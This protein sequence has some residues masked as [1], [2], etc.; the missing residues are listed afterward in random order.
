MWKTPPNSLWGLSSPHTPNKTMWEIPSLSGRSRS[1]FQAQGRGDFRILHVFEVP[2]LSQDLGTLLQ[3]KGVWTHAG[4]LPEP[5]LFST[6]CGDIFPVF[7][8]NIPDVLKPHL[9]KSGLGRGGR[10]PCYSCPGGEG[11]SGIPLIPSC[12]RCLEDLLLPPFLGFFFCPVTCYKGKLELLLCP[13]T[14]QPVHP[15][16]QPPWLPFQTYPGAGKPGKT[17][18][19][20]P[21]LC[22]SHLSLFPC[23][24]PKY[25]SPW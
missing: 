1:P 8:Q 5:L 20:A 12:S 6:D 14:E 13:G 25:L 11:N 2:F 21:G 22:L 3:V 18:P 19:G 23:A 10:D 16:S 24:V 4:G 9:F 17:A 7:F 15:I